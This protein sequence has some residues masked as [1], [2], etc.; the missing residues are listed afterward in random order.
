[1][2]VIIVDDEPLARKGLELALQKYA[3]VEIIAQCEN[4]LE[5]LKAIR[6]KHPD[7]VFLDIRMPRLSGFDV[8]ELLEDPK[9]M[10][11]FV[12]AYDE[13]A[14]RAFEA[15]AI[16]YLLKPVNP[17]RLETTLQ[18]IGYFLNSRK[19]QD[20]QKFLTEQRK[21]AEPLN[22]ILVREGN[23]I[24]I[25][26]VNQVLYIRAED[27]YI[28]IHTEEETFLKYERLSRLKELLDP[29]LFVQ[30]HRSYILNIRFLQ[31]IEAYGKDSHVA[32]LHNKQQLPISRSGFLR[33]KQLFAE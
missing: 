16:D 1:M 3:Q 19:K 9:P 28:S 7:A 25:I 8:V 11:I 15:Q 27:D 2:R 4:G 23:N 31:K 26:A 18:R 20:L 14:L 29:K 17:E 24:H 30:I 13:Y 5:A 33:L 21:T 6:Q 12:T 10:I 32:L 22:R